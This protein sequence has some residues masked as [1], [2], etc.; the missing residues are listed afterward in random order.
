V[1]VAA[2]LAAASV[3]GAGRAAQALPTTEVIVTLKAPSLTAFGRSLTSASHHAYAREL[4]A[5]QAQA[6]RN[7][8]TA[9]P[10]AQIRWHYRIV[11]NG[12]AVVLPTVELSQLA[13]VAGIARVWPNVT[14][15]SLSTQIV[16][17]PALIGADKIWGPTLTTAG[18]GMKIGIIDDGLD[19]THPYFSPTGLTYP[20]G[21]PKGRTDLTTPKVIVQRAFAPASPKYK[22][23]NS[24]FDPQQSFHATHVAGIAAGDH[25][26][27]EG[28]ALI[29]GIAPDAYLG[30]Y[31]ALTIPTPDFGLDGNS[32][33]ITAA[34]ESAVA[35][36]MNVINLSLGEPEVEPSRDI[37]VH[38]IDAAA[39]AGVVP[40][41]AAG[42]DFNQFGYGSISSPA[43]APG[44]I[45]V[46]ATTAT[47][48]IADFSS[49]GPTPV[50]LLLKPDVSAPGVSIT[51]SLPDGQGG[52]WGELGGTSM[53][54]PHVAGGAAL[55]KERH[56]DW[57]VADIKSALVQTADPVRDSSGHEISVLREGG[58]L[59]NLV[60]ADNPLIFAIP[61][62]I[63][64]PVDGGAK[65][66]ALTDATGGA[67]EWTVSA[68]LQRKA[69]GVELGVPPTVTVPGELSISA[70]VGDR[71]SS[72]DV[73]GF[74][75]LTHGSESR[76][77][78]FWV[79]VDHPLLGGEPARKLTKPGL[80]N[81][82]TLGGERK[83]SHYRYPASGDGNYPGPE[84]V[85][86][87]RITRPVANFGVAVVAGK[88]IPHVVY[89]GDE[90]HLVG[91]AGLP[92]VLNPYFRT[93][94]ASRPV[95]GAVLPGVGKYDIVFDTR[96]ASTAGKFEFR[97]WENDARPPKIRVVSTKHDLIAVS[98]TDSGSGIDPESITGTLDG[99]KIQP[100][101]VNGVLTLPAAP[102]SH[103]LSVTF[104]DYQELKNMEDV[105]KIKANT[106]TL[107]R[108]VVVT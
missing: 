37:V 19:A 92:E 103:A 4:A 65:S 73:T 23:A 59:I 93:F 22:Y 63:T 6:A 57:S 88:A 76:R 85:Y 3:S 80:Y 64:F 38:A 56:P 97:F 60:H 52:P 8:L 48:M 10:G 83:I 82:T 79:E 107:T 75:V 39:K 58:G 44:A 5:A 31:K 91:Y 20:P 7:L 70:T 1:L 26:T 104:S 102:G 95:A 74:V 28:S 13:H 50:S 24:P 90:N 14:Y 84:V 30:N 86:S 16:N 89:A 67:G 9:A 21:F 43:N 62:S 69:P 47:D 96:G 17:S 100:H 94:G 87:V 106:A 40:V 108:T 41:I 101:F 11:A 15:H 71:A 32:A 29:S 2:A 61:S 36:G 81:G 54:S 46:A 35:D 18:S 49:G 55:L 42:N 12:F 99:R 25:G 45:T 34:I 105:A 78:P 98:A 33:E 66:V 77:I 27:N 68:Q 72:G 53:A 51:S